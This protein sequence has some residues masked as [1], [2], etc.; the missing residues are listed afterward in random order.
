[1]Q[2]KRASLIATARLMDAFV[3]AGQFSVDETSGNPKL[4]GTAISTAMV[5]P[6]SASRKADP[7]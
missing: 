3:A 4:C 5:H 6:R 7:A 1:M 2:P